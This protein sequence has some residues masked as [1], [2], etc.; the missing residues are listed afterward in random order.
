MA[1]SLVLKVVVAP[2]DYLLYI[3]SVTLINCEIELSY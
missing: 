1:K 2:M 3:T